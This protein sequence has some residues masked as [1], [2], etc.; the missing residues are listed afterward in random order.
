MHPRVPLLPFALALLLPLAGCSAAG[1]LEMTAVKDTA[2]AE[3]ASRSLPAAEDHEAADR[4]ALVRDAVANGSATANGT[5]PPIDPGGL[6][7][8]VDGA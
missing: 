4:R 1:L 3:Q 8:A 2:F 6:P 5:S 7:F